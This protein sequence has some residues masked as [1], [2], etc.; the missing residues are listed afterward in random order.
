MTFTYAM[1]PTLSSST[2]W[3]S[4]AAFF[5]YFA[6]FVD[7]GTYSYWN[8]VPNADNTGFAFTFNPFWGANLTKSQLEALVSPYLSDLDRLGIKVVPNMTEYDSLYK[9][10]A[11]T[12]PPE[13]VGAWNNH[14]ASRLFPRAN[15]KNS[16]AINETVNAVRHAL[17][18]GGIL[19]GY[20]IKAAKNAGANQDNAVNPAWRE[21]VSHFILAGI[22]APDATI[23]EIAKI[24]KTMTTDWMAKWREISPGAGAY[25]SEADINEPDWQQSFFGSNYERLYELKKKMDPWGLLYSPQGVGSEDWEVRDQADWVPTQNGRLCRK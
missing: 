8:I 20:N 9:A 22:W 24:S 18:G 19:I 5:S 7:A 23:G 12:F 13:N 11:G 17:E 4:I 1:S 10:W 21:T 2:F 16:M 15:F 14:A 25:S 3:S 6:T